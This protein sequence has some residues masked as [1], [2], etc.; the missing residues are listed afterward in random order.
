MPY[1]YLEKLTSSDAGFSVWGES[2][3][4]VIQTAG[5]A[6]IGVMVEVVESIK[7][8]EKQQV[9]LKNDDL[10]M[11]LV[12]ALQELIFLKDAYGKLFRYSGCEVR[13]DQ[14]G[15]TFEGEIRGE[16]MDRDRHQF[17]VDVK[18]VTMHNFSLKEH[19][20]QWKA[21]VVVDI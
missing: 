9:T 13:E 18:A 8:V 17:S 19:N 20:G 12:D 21:T 15:Y 4:E 16:L 7:P 2:V 11:L 14:A 10:E 5:D 6:L 1:E 3:C